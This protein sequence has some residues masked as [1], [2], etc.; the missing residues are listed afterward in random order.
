M[1]G[2]LHEWA[3]PKNEN[4]FAHH[5]FQGPL[6]GFVWALLSLG[7]VICGLIG[8]CRPGIGPPE[9]VNCLLPLNVHSDR[10]KCLIVRIESGPPGSEKGVNF[11]PFSPGCATKN[12][13]RPKDRNPPA[14]PSVG[15]PL[16]ILTK[17]LK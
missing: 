1:E 11:Q 15:Q 17:T 3:S 13:C 10:L 6:S 14:R 8:Y 5:I 4:L 12:I 16:S 2:P 7:W 9:P